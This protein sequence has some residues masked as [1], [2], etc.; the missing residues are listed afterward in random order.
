MGANIGKQN[1]SKRT[2]EYHR[3]VQLICSSEENDEK[4]NCTR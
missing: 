1:Y 4:V 2:D 3:G